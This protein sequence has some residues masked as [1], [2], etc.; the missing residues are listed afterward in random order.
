MDAGMPALPV[1][2]ARGCALV[3][4]SAAEYSFLET[5]PKDAALDQRKERVLG[6]I[7]ELNRRSIPTPIDTT[8]AMLRS[9]LEAFPVA[10]FGRVHARQPHMIAAAARAGAVEMI[11][12]RLSTLFPGAATPRPE[13]PAPA[14]TP[15]NTVTLVGPSVGQLYRLRQALPA[16]NFVVYQ[17]MVVSSDVARWQDHRQHIDHPYEWTSSTAVLS[18][19][20]VALLSIGTYH[21]RDFSAALHAAQARR[22]FILHHLSPESLV[23]DFRDPLTQM[24]FTRMGGSIRCGFDDSAPYF[25]DRAVVK[26][27][28]SGD[29]GTESMGV[30]MDALSSFGSLRLLELQCAFGVACRRPTNLNLL[31]DYVVLPPVGRHHKQRAVERRPVQLVVEF[32]S[33]AKPDEQNEITAP[34]DYPH[35]STESSSGPQ[36]CRPPSSWTRSLLTT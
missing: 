30:T 20:V 6:Q 13:E 26:A 11:I 32:L 15:A 3:G 35:C 19:T 7:R 29:L 4:L 17:P 5:L 16:L 12:A 36:R 8:D 2:Y 18:H 24:S 1:R 33:R 28:L 25:D 27:W 31:S 9:L 14:V 34:L 23:G 22:S 21:P 10:D